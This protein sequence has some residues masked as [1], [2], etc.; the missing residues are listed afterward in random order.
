VL[1]FGP[2]KS[3]Y[4]LPMLAT[5]VWTLLVAGEP[6]TKLDT[7]VGREMTDAI[8][9]VNKALGLESWTVPGQEPCVDRGGLEATAKDVKA[10]DA[11][12][13]AESAV[14]KRFPGLGKDYVLG[15]P[16]ADIGPVTVFAIGIDAA[17]G[18]GAYSCDPSR[19]CAP[20]KLTA[21]SK[22]AQRLA[23]RYQKS[24]ANA[25]TIWLPARENVCAGTPALDNSIDEPAVPAPTTVKK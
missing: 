1:F 16:M 8:V 4:A 9:A 6:A 24:C 19:K 15:I 5:L 13:C 14:T 18:Y 17:D 3:S 20:T 7:H 25:K 22:Q 2:A 21:D 10:S 12:R 23:A 11:R